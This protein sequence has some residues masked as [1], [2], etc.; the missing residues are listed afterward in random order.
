MSAIDLFCGAGGL[1]YGLQRSGVDV[2]AGIDVD[3][4]CQYPFTTNNSA[5]FYLRDIRSVTGDELTKI[6]G[7]DDNFKVLAGCAPCQPFSTLRQAGK[8]NKD[9]KWNLLRE[10]G[11]LVYETE[12]EFI[13]MENVPGIART[14]VFSDF[15]SGLTAN[16][17]LV[18]HQV[19]FLPNYGLP[20]HRKRLVLV[21]SRIGKIQ[22][23]KGTHTP[24][25]YVT[26]K[27]VIGEIEPIIHGQQSTSDPMHRT[28]ALSERNLQRIRSSS[29]GGTWREWPEGLQLACHKKETGKYYA[30]VYGRMEWD[31][32]S[33]TITT[34][35]YN[36]GTGRFGHPEQD[37]AISLRE[38]SALQG[39]PLDYKF[40]PSG[41]HI[42]IDKIG[43]L[44]GNAV[45]PVLGAVIGE[46]IMNAL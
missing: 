16:G 45:P 32:P 8:K 27:D 26:V 7:S 35:F 28:Q 42:T 4:D 25:K 15:V 31:S 11:R 36:Y 29:P 43:R 41:E 9:E 10:F 6:W 1:A 34:Q 33:P 19:V 37:R 13:T 12:P 3:P 39:F 14:D 30:S 46:S 17:Y 21:A 18:D 40:V 2:V 23:P 5:D 24:E 20:Q 38:G 44:I 22:V